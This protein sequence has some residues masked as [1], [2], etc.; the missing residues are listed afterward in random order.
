MS[1]AL[2][3]AFRSSATLTSATGAGA[4]VVEVYCK[5]VSDNTSETRRIGSR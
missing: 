5:V 1:L 2:R 3:L 4:N